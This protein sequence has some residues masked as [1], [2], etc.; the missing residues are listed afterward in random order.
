[1]VTKEYKCHCCGST[2]IVKAGRN[3][4]GNQRYRCKDCRVQRVLEYKPK[5][6]EEKKEEILRAYQER[7]S[8]RGLR[9]TFG[10]TPEIVVKWL[11]KKATNL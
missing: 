9:R 4:N 6:S 10:V 7:S 8:L 3:R 11:K 1:M 2:N 5:Y